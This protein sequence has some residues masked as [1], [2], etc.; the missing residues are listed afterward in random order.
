M[1]GNQGAHVRLTA[2]IEWLR[3][4]A[5]KTSVAAAGPN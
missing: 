5:Y 1:A 2:L 4:I 3:S